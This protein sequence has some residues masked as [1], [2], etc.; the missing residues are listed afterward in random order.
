[1]LSIAAA[2]ALGVPQE[3]VRTRPEAAPAKT[4]RP[5]TRAQVKDNLYMVSGEGGNIAMLTTPAGVLLVD[6]MFDRNHADVMAQVKAVSQAPLRYVVNTHQHDDHAGGDLKMLPIAEVIAHKSVR[7]NL[8]NIKQP[9]LED[10]PGTPI[11]LPRVTFSKQFSVHLGGVE[12]RAYPLRAGPHERRR[13]HL[14]PVAADGAHG[15]PVPGHRRRGPW[16]GR[17][18]P[19]RRRR[20]AARGA[21]LRGLR[22]GRQLPDVVCV[23][24]RRCSRWTSTR[25]IPGHGPVQTRADVVRF[26]GDLEAM[27]DRLDRPDPGRREPRRGDPHS[28]GGLQ[29]AV[30]R[31]PAEPAHRRLPA[32]SSRWTR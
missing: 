32:V 17:Q 5:L 22:A 18:A 25:S 7:S 2:Q 10:T 8:A 31:L 30:H 9:Y 23:A 16:A 3:S 28:R 12:V 24:R 27:R 4:P 21:D 29:L 26:K 20:P 6:D 14:L 1:M 13:H 19:P 11:G 15:R